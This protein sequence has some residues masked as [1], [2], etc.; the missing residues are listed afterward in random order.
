MPNEDN[1]VHPS[2][3]E[4]YEEYMRDL[5]GDVYQRMLNRRYPDRSPG[6]VRVTPYRHKCKKDGL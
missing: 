5:Q 4:V 3:R 2:F 1:M 6:M